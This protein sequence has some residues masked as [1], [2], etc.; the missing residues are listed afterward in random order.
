[1]VDPLSQTYLPGAGAQISS[2][3]ASQLASQI[4]SQPLQPGPAPAYNFQTPDPTPALAQTYMPGQALNA[5]PQALLSSSSASPF[6]QTYLPGQQSTPS[7]ALNA[8]PQDPLSS[9][10]ASPFMQTYVLGQQPAPGLS[11]AVTNYQGSTLLQHQQQNQLLAAYQPG[12]SPSPLMATQSPSPA[13]PARVAT[14]ATV[15][16]V[17]PAAV[18]ATPGTMEGRA[19]EPPTTVTPAAGPPVTVPPGGVGD[20]DIHQDQACGRCGG[21]LVRLWSAPANNADGRFQCG[22]CNGQYLYSQ[23]ADRCFFCGWAA[24]M[25]CRAG[26]SET[27]T[28]VMATR[29]A[30]G[31]EG[32]A[33]VTR[34]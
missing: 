31:A 32:L 15:D 2:Q 22:L 9:S 34:M 1:M 3:V 19:V 4:A 11:P 20:Q 7:Q 30:P 29:A 33:T 26:Q 18:Q 8:L 16:R 12:P 21:P 6:M 27:M 28:K 5:H 17:R 23:G 14:P 13:Q 24:C 25:T 10:S